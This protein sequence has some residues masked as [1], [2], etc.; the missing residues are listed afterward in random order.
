[1]KVF[2]SAEKAMQ[3]LKEKDILSL[4]SLC[5]YNDNKFCGNWCAL[6]YFSPEE[7]SK[8]RHVSTYVVL[9]CKVD[10]K[11]LYVEKIIEA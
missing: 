3:S 11:R 7:D 4:N 2:K 5:P 1:M 10:Q 9:G 6:F 8:D